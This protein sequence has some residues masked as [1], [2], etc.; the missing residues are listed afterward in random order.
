MRSNLRTLTNRPSML[1]CDLPTGAH[2]T[3]TRVMAGDGYADAALLRRLAD[4]GFIAGEPVRV[5]RRGPGGREPVAVQVGETL[6][7]MR[8]VEARCIEVAAD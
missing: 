8:L 4:L 5:V 6:L 1:L 7:G 2:A 3:V